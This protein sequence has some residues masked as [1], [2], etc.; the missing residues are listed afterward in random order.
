[1][2]ERIEK[3]S[4]VNHHFADRLLRRID[5]L[6]T[7]V[8]VGLDP[9]LSRFPSALL[10]EFKLPENSITLKRNLMEQAARCIVKFNSIVIEATADLAATVKPQCAYY[11]RFGHYGMAALEETVLAAKKAGI[12]VVMDGKRN[13]IGSTAKQYALAYLGEEAE[14]GTAAISSDALT[15]NPYLGEDGIKP[16]TEQC[17]RHGNGI[18]ILVKT[19]NPSSRDLQELRL[20]G[21]RTLAET[22]ASLVDVWGRELI[23]E[24][25]YSSVGAVVGATHPDSIRSLREIMPRTLFLLPGYGAQ[26]GTAENVRPAFD[27][28]GRGAV[29]NSSR[30]ILYGYPQGA[31]DFAYSI[32]QAAL[33]MRDDLN[34]TLKCS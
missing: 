6:D 17:A 9:D 33:K 21:G 16:F 28:N 12:P 14:D 18:F 15:V 24:S 19:S 1:M 26:G 2:P 20:E 34:R 8:C 31:S 29:V 30:G 3:P 4:S 13:D 5:R 7:R 25:G 27:E 32:R 10:R 23:G 22:V 11:E